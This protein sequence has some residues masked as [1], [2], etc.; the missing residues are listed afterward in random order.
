MRINLLIFS[1]S[2]PFVFQLRYRA[3]PFCG[4]RLNAD[5]FFGCTFLGP[6][7]TREVKSAAREE[8]FPEVFSL[9]INR[10]YFCFLAKLSV[11]PFDSEHAALFYFSVDRSNV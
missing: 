6:V 8:C 7:C 11:S 5:H 2:L 10:Y 1:G 4:T 3:C 9:V